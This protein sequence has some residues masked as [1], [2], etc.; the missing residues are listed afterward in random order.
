MTI[1]LFVYEFITT[2]LASLENITH[3]SNLNK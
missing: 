1:V 2:K 3:S